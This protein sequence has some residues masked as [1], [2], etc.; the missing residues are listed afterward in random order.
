MARPRKYPLPPDPELSEPEVED[1]EPEHFDEMEPAQLVQIALENPR[2]KMPPVMVK[3]LNE[4]WREYVLADDDQAK[5]DA[6]NI[7][8]RLAR[9]SHDELHPGCRK[10]TITVPVLKRADGRGGVWYVRI[11]E[12][13]YV[14]QVDVWECTARQIDELVHLHG[15]VEANRMSEG[16]NVTFDLDTGS[17]VAERARAIQ[18]A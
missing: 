2:M 18:R 9:A 16:Q 7:K 11:N 12:R 10:I 8:T 5:R 15:Q 1:E 17:M 3:A 13:V 14:G 4:M 6:R